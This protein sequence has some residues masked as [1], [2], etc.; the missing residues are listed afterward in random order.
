MLIIAR[1][2]N[3]A[4]ELDQGGNPVRGKAAEGAPEARVLA[5]S[6]LELPFLQRITSTLITLA[7]YAAV[8][9]LTM[10]CI[11]N[12]RDGAINDRAYLEIPPVDLS[13][14]ASAV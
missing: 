8:V 5:I 13:P 12:S 3:S 7:K 9:M 1:K 4:A 2:G 6:G 10:Q 14:T 11:H